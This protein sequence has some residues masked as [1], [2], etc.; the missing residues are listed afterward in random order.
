MQDISRLS[1]FKS[2]PELGY[3]VDSILSIL[4]YSF[5]MTLRTK[6]Q[7]FSVVVNPALAAYSHPVLT[8]SLAGDWCLA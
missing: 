8:F 5:L 3:T 6:I 4:R 7:S 1:H 2:P